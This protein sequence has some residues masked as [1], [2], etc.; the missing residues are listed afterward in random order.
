MNDND[1]IRSVPPG[2]VPALWHQQEPGTVQPAEDP[3]YLTRTGEAAGED[4]SV[5]PIIGGL[6]AVEGSA[7]DIGAPLADRGA[8]LADEHG[9]PPDQA[10]HEDTSS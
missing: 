10:A 5:A 4:G 7:W 3:G 6:P 1:A 2:E 8:D 9:S